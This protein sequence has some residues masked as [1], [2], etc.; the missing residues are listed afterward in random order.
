ME[1]AK[2]REL[3]VIVIHLAFW[4]QLGVLTRI[5]VGKFF[6]DGCKGYWGVCLTSEG[7]DS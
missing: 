5:Y 7:E 1:P 4:A 3:V 6:S 2:A